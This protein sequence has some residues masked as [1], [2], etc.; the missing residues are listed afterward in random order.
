MARFTKAD[1]VSH[2]LQSPLIPVFYHAEEPYARRVLQACY[3]GGVRLFEFTNRGPNAFE[4][5]TDL[6]QF[7]EAEYPDLM[8]GAGTIYTVEEAERFISA[9]ADYIVQPVIG[10]EVAALCQQQD[11]AWLPGVSTLNEV[12]QASQLGATFAKLFPAAMLG[13]NYLKT[14]SAPLPKVRFMATGGIQPDAETMAAWMQAGATCVGVDSRLLQ[15][16][17][18][19]ALTAQVRELL[20][21]MQPKAAQ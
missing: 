3:E 2:A 4:I 5:F 16:Q 17:D 6:Q 18:P 19:A 7:V 1:A 21:A 13:P 15:T 11:L 12:Y 14:I 8:L 9:G 10:A 20:A